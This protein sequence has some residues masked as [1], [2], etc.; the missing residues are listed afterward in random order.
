MH[1]Y[2]RLMAAIFD[3]SSHPGVEEYIPT[4][5]TVL[6][7]LK[8]GVTCRQF[9]DITLESRHPMYIRSDGRHFCGRALE[10][11]ET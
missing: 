2:F 4:G 7:D 11:F 5:P 8:N 1:V 3:F 10:Y 9:S 6:L